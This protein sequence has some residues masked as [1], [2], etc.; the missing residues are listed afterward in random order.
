MRISILGV[1]SVGSNIA[2]KINTF[3]N[4]IT[5]LNIYDGDIVKE[6]NLFNT[7][8]TE[9]DIGQ[10]KA[11]I[12]KQKLTQQYPNIKVQAFPFF[13][14]DEKISGELIIDTRDS[15]HYYQKSHKIYFNENDL[16]VDARKKK[17]FLPRRIISE[18]YSI[19][20]DRNTLN[21]F[22]ETYINNFNQLDEKFVV[23]KD[24]LSIVELNYSKAHIDLILSSKYKNQFSYI[25]SS[26][27]LQ[28]FIKNFKFKSTIY[29]F[30]KGTICSYD[31]I[32]KSDLK[33][34]INKIDK[35]IFQCYNFFRGKIILLKTLP[36]GDLMICPETYA[37]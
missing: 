20:L 1:G 16:F 5:E 26:I 34:L 12:L 14:S 15:S 37:C 27:E 31:E 8:Y 2:T 13:V 33:N 9:H 30:Y 18:D 19:V 7:P 25:L 32:V 22:I 17:E 21:K 11:L 36:G 6:K 10:N 29:V 3:P 23:I 4:Q 24:D 35:L 28:K